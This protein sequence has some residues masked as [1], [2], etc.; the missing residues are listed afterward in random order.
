MRDNAVSFM[1]YPNL[2]KV[3]ANWHFGAIELSPLEV[4]M[5]QNGFLQVSAAKINVSQIRECQVQRLAGWHAVGS[6]R[7]D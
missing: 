2:S 7:S 5:E 6:R 3:K 4:G 1:R